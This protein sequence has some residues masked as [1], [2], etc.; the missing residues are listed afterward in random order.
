TNKTDCILHLPYFCRGEVI[1]GFGR[2]SKELGI[3][4]AIFPDSV[5]DNL[6]ANIN[7]G[8][9]YGWACVGNGDVH[10]MVMSIGWNPY[11]KNTKKSMLSCRGI[12]FEDFYGEILSVVMVGYICP[13][14]TF[15]S[16]GTLHYFK[17][18][19]QKFQTSDFYSSSFLFFS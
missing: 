9:C 7:T 11:Y 16:L 10:R 14:R 18:P 2:G 4:T 6:P 3:P 12:T 13:E 1:R 15:N 5:V 8:I 19:L 17:L